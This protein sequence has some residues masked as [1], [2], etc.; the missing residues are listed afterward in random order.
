[1]KKSSK[2]LVSSLAVLLLGGSGVGYYLYSTNNN[3]KQSI[4]KLV[5][6]KV[7]KKTDKSDMPKS[8]NKSETV[9]KAKD[10]NKEANGKVDSGFESSKLASDD[11]ISEVTAY[12]TQL[13]DDMKNLSVDELNN[14]YFIDDRASLLKP[15]YNTGYSFDLNSLKVHKT[16]ADYLLEWGMYL[17][18]NSLSHRVVGTYDKNMKV[19]RII[20]V[21]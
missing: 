18:R 2:I 15:Y 14:K 4:I 17:K 12:L 16:K 20:A 10:N 7:D 9:D 3:I 11:E 8:S 19:I 5:I 1:M 13:N 21:E 6:P